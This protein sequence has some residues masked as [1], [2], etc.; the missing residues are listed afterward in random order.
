LQ[1]KK[2]IENAENCLINAISEL[3]DNCLAGNFPLNKCQFKKLAKYKNILRRLKRKTK[4]QTRRRILKQYG[5]VL[6]ALVVPALGFL[7][8]I[9]GTAISKKI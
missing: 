9:I 5:G 3:A 4:V 7:A 8:S 2:I 1:Q 6:P